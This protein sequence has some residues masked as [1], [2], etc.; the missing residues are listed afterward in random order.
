[1]ANGQ[2]ISKQTFKSQFYKEERSE[3]ALAVLCAME[4]NDDEN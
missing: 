3:A 4:G 2:N 1:M